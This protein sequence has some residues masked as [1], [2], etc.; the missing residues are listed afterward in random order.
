MKA[1]YSPFVSYG[2]LFVALERGYFAEQGI[3]MD[4][5]AFDASGLMI[6]PLSAGQLDI[7]SGVP[8]PALFNALSRGVDLKLLVANSYSDGYLM[9]R[10]ELVDSGGLQTWGDLRGKRVSFHVEGSSA[11]YILRDAFYRNGLT[12]QDVE[13]QRLGNPDI[14]PALANGAVDAAVA[15]EPVPV[16]VEAQGTAVRW[17]ILRDVVG[18]HVASS[19]LAGP[20]LLNRGEG[21]V[22]RLVTAVIQGQ[23]EF[24][25]GI[26]NGKVTD[27]GIREILSKWTNLPSQTIALTTVIEGPPNGRIDLDDLEL[28]QDFWLGEGLRLERLD[29]SKFVESK[30]VDAAVA[31]LR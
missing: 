14:P 31:N 18:L 30:Y 17:S 7:G 23:R 29:L 15:P 28:Q 10:K 16:A 25:A 2:P 1:G 13:V 6:P 27:S 3:D 26:Q 4:F 12:L 19:L 11:D 22:T 9:V 21:P 20:S 5:V 24:N 8:G